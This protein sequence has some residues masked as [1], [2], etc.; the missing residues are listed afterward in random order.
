M[1]ANRSRTSAVKVHTTAVV[2]TG[3][4]LILALWLSQPSLV[5][6][7]PAIMPPPLACQPEART[8]IAVLATFTTAAGMAIA[9]AIGAVMR[10]RR[11]AQIIVA[12]VGAS[13]FVIGVVAVVVLLSSRSL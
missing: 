9:L 5:A 12:V 8:Q 11:L 13:M 3:G 2:L 1:S 10:D 7:C 6:V 4:M